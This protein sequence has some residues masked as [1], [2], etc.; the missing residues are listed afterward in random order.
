MDLSKLPKLSNTNAEQ[1]TQTQS[2]AETDA[3]TT[4]APPRRVAEYQPA[5]SYTG[6]GSLGADVWFSAIVGLLLIGVG[7]TFA[8]FLTAKVTGQPFH[9]NATWMEGPKSG[10]EVDYFELQGYTAWTDMGV[11]LF[12]LVLLFEAATMAAAQLRPGAFSRGLLSVA[13]VLTLATVLLNLVVC[14]KLLSA[15]VLP[16]W[17]GLAVAFGGWILADEWRMFKLT[18]R[19]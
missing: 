6:G 1:Q 11:F 5:G 2:S 16:L 18:Q 13:V 12:G 8:R 4:P 9:T 3:T 17:S 14:A 10:S 19:V 7:F 15:G